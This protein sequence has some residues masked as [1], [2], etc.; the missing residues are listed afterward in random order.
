MQYTV[1]IGSNFHIGP[2]VIMMTVNITQ[3]YTPD[4][5]H[6]GAPLQIIRD[7]VEVHKETREKQNWYRCNRSNKCSYLWNRSEDTKCYRHTVSQE[8][9]HVPEN[10]NS[11]HLKRCGGR[12]NQQ[13]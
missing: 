10:W 7:S 6:I 8:V 11:W 1:F 5:G 2:S 12:P 3:I 9:L 4:I 13:A